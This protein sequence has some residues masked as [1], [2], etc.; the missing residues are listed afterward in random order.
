MLPALE[1]LFERRVLL[2]TGK[3]GVGRTTVTAALAR[4]AVRRGKHVLLTEATPEEE[5]TEG[6]YSPLARC[7]GHE[8][9]PSA[10]TEWEP[11]LHACAL[12][13]RRGQERFLSQ[14]LHSAALA[15]FALGSEAIQRLLSAAP[16]FRELGLM[17][18][19]DTLLSSCDPSTC[20][21]IDM[22]AT[23]HALAFT[24]LPKVLLKVIPAGPLAEGLRQV[25][26]LLADPA[27]TAAVVVTLPERLPATECAELVARFSE[28]RVSV[29][30]VVLNRFLEN[31][32]SSSEVA[33]LEG[34]LSSSRAPGRES[35][36][37][38]TEAAEVR[39][40]LEREG[41]APVV[42]LPDEGHVPSARELSAGL[43]R[44]LAPEA[45][46]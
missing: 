30:A 16:S 38:V 7:F 32:L 13:A 33:A 37:R 27:H 17:N 34:Y 31:P 41:R 14:A 45:R 11:G 46:N 40:W 39:L 18:D 19:L 10:R 2:V 15:R 25:E 24:G 21:L 5:F 3:G 36:R 35:L 9:V 42:V 26:R 12:S 23:G 44:V 22:P 1:S 29:G 6:A 28:E 20:V 8:R 4:A 43:A